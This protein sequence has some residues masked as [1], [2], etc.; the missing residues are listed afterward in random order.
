MRTAPDLTRTRRRRRTRTSVRV[1]GWIVALGWLLAASLLALHASS[2]DRPTISVEAFGARPDDGLDDGP[3]INA[4]FA[5]AASATA[6]VTVELAAGRYDLVSPSSAGAY[7]QVS[8]ASDVTVVGVGAELEF[9]VPERVGLAIT[10]SRNVT[11]TGLSLDYAVAPFAQGTVVGVDK[12]AGTIDFRLADG[13]PTLDEPWFDAANWG[14]RFDA[15]TQRVA[16]GGVDYYPISF[17]VTPV[18]TRTWRLHV[19]DRLD[20]FA[21][22]DGFVIPIR[23]PGA[24]VQ[25]RRSSHT[26]LDRLIVHSAPGPAFASLESTA[27]TLQRS[28]VG[29]RA[30][31]GRWIST[32][33][34]GLHHSGGDQGPVVRGNVFSRMLDD[35]INVYSVPGLVREVAPVEGGSGESLTVSRPFEL[36]PGQEIEV[37][38]PVAGAVRGTARVTAVEAV[39]AQTWRL[40]LDRAITG[41]RGGPDAMAADQLYLLDDV[42]TDFE[43][44]DNEF[45]DHRARGIVVRGRRGRI[46]DNRFHRLSG[47]VVVANDPDWPEGN[48]PS[49]VAVT[50]NE[51]DDVAASGRYGAAI[52]V[53]GTRLG[54]EVAADPLIDAVV[55]SGNVIRGAE[56]AV[57]VGAATR[58]RVADTTVIRE[59]GAAADPVVVAEHSHDVVIAGLDVVDAATR[60]APCGSLPAML[61]PGVD[62]S[63]AITVN[64]VRCD[65]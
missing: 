36:R 34:D 6:A 51:F 44:V 39:T 49:D 63:S 23:G 4:A 27:T 42:G 26:T 18:A 28:H 56:V 19:G 17:D 21:V 35:G 47:G 25:L 15:S 59:A 12:T 10:D 1:V 5:V 2:P 61:V 60:A 13:Y 41:I 3:A 54:H 14:T 38:D 32:S 58:V 37:F 11:V 20:D 57:Y 62:Q 22:D 52:T 65:G 16:A 55:I 64:G 30:G 8:G 53:Q 43:I 45:S 48:L 31:S 24:A 40:Q 33:A 29:V 9:A 7:L 50:D 46:S